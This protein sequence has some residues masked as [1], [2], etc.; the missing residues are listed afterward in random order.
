MSIYKEIREVQQKL[1]APKGQ[2]NTFGN[3]NYRSAEDILEAVK[4]ALNEHK[5]TMVISDKIVNLGDRYYVYAT[6]TIN[7]DNG[8]TAEATGVAREAFDKKG[9][10]DAQITGSASSYARKYALNGLFNIDDTKDAD[11]NEYVNNA[12]P[13]VVRDRAAEQKDGPAPMGETTEE[14]LTRAKK[15]IN[16]ELTQANYTSVDAKRAFVSKVIEKETIEN[17]NEADEVMTAL[18]NEA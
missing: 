9:M 12:K 18:E 14:T 7:N 13:A 1:R 10:D 2:R 3:Y 15:K 5:L 16:E 11:T 4:P 17:L 6:A 8:E